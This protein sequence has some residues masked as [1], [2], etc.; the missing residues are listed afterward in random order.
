MAVADGPNWTRNRF[1]NSSHAVATSPKEAPSADVLLL[2]QL[3]PPSVLYR[4]AS[5]QVSVAKRLRGFLGLIAMVSST[6]LV[7]DRVMFTL[8]VTVRDAAVKEPAQAKEK[9]GNQRKKTE[10]YCINK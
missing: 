9:R 3:V 8:V 2:L 7:A 6:L 5:A 1:P 10:L 4:A